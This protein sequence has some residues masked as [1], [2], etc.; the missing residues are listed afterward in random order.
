M[1]FMMKRRRRRSK[2]YHWRKMKK[3]R[4]RRRRKIEHQ[5]QPLCWMKVVHLP[6]IVGLLAL[7]W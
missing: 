1:Y 4:R 6:Q 5:S 2:N 3:R 7:Q